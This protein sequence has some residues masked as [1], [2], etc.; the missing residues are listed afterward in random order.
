MTNRNVVARV[1]SK[2]KQI[3]GDDIISDRAILAELRS[4]A[5]LYIKRETDRRRLLTV[6]SLFTTI[7]CIEMIE[8]PLA[9]CCSYIS[10]CTIRRSKERIPQIGEG[11]WGYIV[12]SVQSMDGSV[13]FNMGTAKRYVD[14][15]HLKLKKNANM[16]WIQD[17]YIYVS[18][19]DIEYIKGRAY[20]E[21]D[22]PYRLK[23]CDNTAEDDECVNPLDEPFK[24]PGYLVENVISTVEGKYAQ[25]FMQVKVDETDNDNPNT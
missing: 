9:E 25:I 6:D 7:P 17:G 12:E 14:T 20:F 13:K 22:I 8:V 21:E 24:C 4:T 11:L 1:R 18:N 2:L 19:S 15:L 16:F 5:N 3:S 23:K 10:P